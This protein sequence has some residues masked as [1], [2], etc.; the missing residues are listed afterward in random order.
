MPQ[1]VG[2][3]KPSAMLAAI[4]ASTAE[5]PA[6]SVSMAIRLA[7]GWAV[8]AA[9][10]Q[11]QTAERVANG[12]PVT[13]SPPRMPVRSVGLA[14]QASLHGLAV[15]REGLHL[16]RA[17]SLTPEFSPNSVMAGRKCRPPKNTL[18]AMAALGAATRAIV[19]I[20]RRD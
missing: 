12:A 19:C 16:V 17:R 1:A 8:A 15:G 2:S 9:P 18:P 10:L 6:L 20:G 5:P 13:R 11:P 4:A 3:R 7:S 14:M